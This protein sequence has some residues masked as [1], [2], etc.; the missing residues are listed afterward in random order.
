VGF[1]GL[2]RIEEMAEGG[3]LAVGAELIEVDLLV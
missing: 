3:Y 2:R 1:D